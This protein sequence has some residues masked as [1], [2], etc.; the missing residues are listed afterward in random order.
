MHHED[1]IHLGEHRDWGKILDRIEGQFGAIQR[2]VRTMCSARGSA[3][4]VAIGGCLRDQLH[5]DIATATG[6]IFHDERLS[7]LLTELLRDNSTYRV[8]RTSRLK[9]NH[10]PNWSNGGPRR[11]VLSNRAER[12]NAERSKARTKVVLI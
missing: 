5:A 3:K 7:P 2:C 4:G 10:Y 11:R 6:P 8:D 12:P 9:R 1:V